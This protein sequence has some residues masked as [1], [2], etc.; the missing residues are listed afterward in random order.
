MKLQHEMKNKQDKNAIA[1]VRDEEDFVH[2]PRA[3][4]STKQ[5]TWIITHAP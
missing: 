4:A 1:A 3:P 2:I 5:G